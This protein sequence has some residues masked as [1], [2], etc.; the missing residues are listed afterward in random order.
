MLGLLHS[1]FLSQF[2]INV[3]NIH[4]MVITTRSP[5]SQRVR[6]ASVV[7]KYVYYVDYN[8]K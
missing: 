4:F 6:Y 5:P 7:L 3:Y 1:D 8:C 2:G